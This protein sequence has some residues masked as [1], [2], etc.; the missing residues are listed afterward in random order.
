[1]DDNDKEVLL[2]TAFGKAPVE[3]QTAANNYAASLKALSKAKTKLAN[4]ASDLEAAEIKNGEI[5][6]AY[7]GVLRNWTPE[8]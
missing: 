3:V 6:K 5:A 4:A 8:V 1:M 7:R 2:A